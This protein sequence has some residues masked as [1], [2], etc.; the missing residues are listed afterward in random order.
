[1]GTKL[2]L[3]LLLLLLPRFS[4]SSS[5]TSSSLEN[6]LLLEQSESSIVV[7][8]ARPKARKPGLPS[9]RSPSRAE[10]VY[11]PRRA[12]GSAQDVKSPS[13]ALKPGLLAVQKHTYLYTIHNPQHLRLL[14]IQ[15]DSLYCCISCCPEIALACYIITCRFL[16]R[17]RCH[18]LCS[19]PPRPWVQ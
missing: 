8:K 18:S 5:S 10:P 12:L 6:I 9:L 1:M 16:S 13:R 15:P 2:R 11:R 14:S 4:S 17:P 7:C 3:V 19:P